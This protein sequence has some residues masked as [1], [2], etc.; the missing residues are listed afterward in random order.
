M[1]VW[2][3]IHVYG[4]GRFHASAESPSEMP[5][6]A[7]EEQRYL[8]TEEELLNEKRKAFEAGQESAIA[9][10][11]KQGLKVT[12]ERE[13]DDYLKSQQEENNG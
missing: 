1:K 7:D 4:P 13:F 11:E 3:D 5:Y 9:Y 2:T 6:G 8:L 12:V 10:L